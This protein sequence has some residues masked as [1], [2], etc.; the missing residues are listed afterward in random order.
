MG[1]WDDGAYE[2]FAPELDPAAAV[3][4]AL[5]APQAGERAL[6]VGCGSGNA[7]VRLAAA[8]TVLTAVDP[9]ERLLQVTRD[10]LRDAGH[11]AEVHRAGGDDPFATLGAVQL[12]AAGAEALPFAD[13][14]FDVVVSVFAAIF[15]PEPPAALAELARVT[16]PGGRVL[17]AVW[18]PDGA[19]EQ[20]L[21]PLRRV[22]AAA[23]PGGG[24][25]PW[26]EPA[27][28]GAHLPAGTAV[29]VHADEVVFTA[30]SGAAWVAQHERVH[31]IWRTA[32]RALDDEQ[33]W[34]AL[35]A[36][37]AEHLD[38]SSRSATGLEVGAAYRV[39]TLRPG[40]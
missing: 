37:V 17:L 11:V 20:A 26:H 31:P 38:A 23:R 1:D 34:V 8:G 6:D 10:R 3:T 39:L 27:A 40:R 21:A 30:A 24:P 15:S 35:Q 12:H 29:E 7:T 9:G 2:S 5:A 14:A 18:D 13:D 19:V 4:V 16:A 36:A 32:R 22:L 33:A 28:L 25:F